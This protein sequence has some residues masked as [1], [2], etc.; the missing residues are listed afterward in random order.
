VNGDGVT[1]AF[2]ESVRSRIRTVVVVGGVDVHAGWSRDGY[3]EIITAKGLV[4]SV[5][6]SCLNGELEHCEAGKASVGSGFAVNL[7]WGVLDVVALESDMDVV[8]SRVGWVVGDGVGAVVVVHH[9]WL[10][11][12]AIGVGDVNL[13]RITAIVSGLTV[14]VEGVD[15]EDS[16]L[17]IHEGLE[18]R[19]FSEGVVGI[20]RSLDVGVEWSILDWCSV[21]A[22]VDCVISRGSNSV[23]DIVGSISVVLDVRMDSL[24]TSDGD[25]EGIATSGDWVAVSID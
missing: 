23:L 20:G 17:V 15:G 24:G 5:L 13:E 12:G 16:G 10:L 8:V 19:S 25:L 4:V 14:L 6:V 2:G 21:E 9:V 18:S 11:V 22:D 1:T 7:D 3:A